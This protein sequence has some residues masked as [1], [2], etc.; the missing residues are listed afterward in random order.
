MLHHQRAIVGKQVDVFRRGRQGKTAAIST[1][2]TGRGK[3]VLRT[4][5]VFD[6]SCGGRSAGETRSQTGPR[7]Q[8]GGRRRLRAVCSLGAASWRGDEVL[9]HLNGVAKGRHVRDHAQVVAVRV[10][11]VLR[12]KED[13]HAKVFAGRI[14]R[15]AN[16]GRRV[17]RRLGGQ[18][19]WVQHPHQ[20][21]QGFAIAPVACEIGDVADRRNIGEVVKPAEQKIAGGNGRLRDLLRRFQVVVVNVKVKHQRQDQPEDSIFRASEEIRGVDVGA[22]VWG[23]S[24]GGVSQQVTVGIL[25]N[26][27][28][29]QTG[30]ELT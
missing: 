27:D 15:H 22:S 18:A 2:C 9:F 8:T 28:G 11:Q 6:R 19:F 7:G 21:I 1:N 23:A 10:C 3:C 25:E 5:P 16:T 24:Q 30:R 26:L 20:G 12:R 29:V 17:V 13:R 4:T 14:L